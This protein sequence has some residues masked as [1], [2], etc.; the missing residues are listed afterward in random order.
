[1]K[2]NKNVTYTY[3]P[4][5]YLKLREGRLSL[6]GTC[7]SAK[8]SCKE[9]LHYEGPVNPG[10]RRVRWDPA[11]PASPGALPDPAHPLPD[12]HGTY[13]RWVLRTRCA[14]VM[15][16]MPLKKYIFEAAVTNCL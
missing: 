12:T 1:M 6:L 11:G 15:K 5:F 7:K 8:D 3:I 10:G 4:L 16:I 2:Y 14:H 9:I 13:I